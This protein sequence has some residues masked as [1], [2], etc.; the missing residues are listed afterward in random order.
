MSVNPTWF[1]R[2]ESVSRSRFENEVVERGPRYI[3]PVAQGK[4]ESIF[5]IIS[6]SEVHSQSSSA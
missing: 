3:L 6:T 4:A 2:E 1:V 5:G